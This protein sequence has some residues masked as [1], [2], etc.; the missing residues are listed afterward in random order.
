MKKIFLQILFLCFPVFLIAQVMPPQGEKTYSLNDTTVASEDFNPEEVK[1]AILKK[2][3]R[4]SVEV[5]AT[6]GA[7][8]YYGSYFGTYLAPHLSYDITP[9]FTLSGGVSLANYYGISNFTPEYTAMPMTSIYI[10]GAY[11]LTNNLAVYGAVHQQIDLLNVPGQ[12]QNNTYN[13]NSTSVRMG[14]K[15]KLS[16]NVFI[17]GEVGF[18]NRPY[19]PYFGGYQPNP[20]ASPIMNRRSNPFID[21]F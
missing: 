5:G 13:L 6:F 17:Q 20:F 12:A 2:R 15:Y 21:P 19:N 11:K 10:E 7:S 9:R 8:P 14:F 16:D 18:S 4:V 1:D 3:F